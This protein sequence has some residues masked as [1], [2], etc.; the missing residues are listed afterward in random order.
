MTLRRTRSNLTTRTVLA[1]GRPL[2]S[3]LLV[4]AGALAASGLAEL[5]LQRVVYRVGVHIPR[6]GAFL[7]TYEVATW[8]GDLAFRLTAVLLAITAVLFAAWL[9]RDRTGPVVGLLMGALVAANLLAWPLHLSIGRELAPILFAL[10]VA[11]IVG[12]TLVASGPAA[13]KAAALAVA[14]TLLLGQYRVGFGDLG[15][16]AVRIGEVQTATEI[17]LLVS[18]G[19]F[20]AAAVGAAHRKASLAI[21]SI[22]VGVLLSAYA[23][24][25]ATVAIV[26]LWATGVTMSLPGVL[27]LLAF[28]AAAFAAAAWLRSR[29]TR[30]LAIG[31]ALLLVAGVQPQVL[32]HDITA[33]IGLTLLTLWPAPEG[34]RAAGSEPQVEL[35]PVLSGEVA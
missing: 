21:A 3:S 13:L 26:S 11:W 32:H 17:G 28:G 34:I 33:L 14:V 16:D 4:F 23:R 35:A 22:G 9:V 24:E 8:S 30:H 25:P 29:H 1:A 18:A 20:A 2:S 10:A 6:N 5:V 19:L 12:Q 27:Y 31:L 7:R 15:V